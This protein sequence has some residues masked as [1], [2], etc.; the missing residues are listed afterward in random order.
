MTT[1]TTEEQICNIALSWIG[2]DTVTD[3]DT[4]GTERADLCVLHYPVCRDNV[5]TE[6][7]WTF[8]V[9][10]N[11]LD[12]PDGTAP[13]NPEWGQRFPI[14]ST[15]LRVLTVH[16]PT[17]VFTD[18]L[19]DSEPSAEQIPWVREGDWIL[20]NYDE[21]S[22]RTIERITTVADFPDVFVQALAARLAMD[23][24]IPLTQSLNLHQQMAAMYQDKMRNAAAMDGMQGRSRRIRHRGL[25]ARR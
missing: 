21:I 22:V 14:A 15:T 23:L 18:F 9:E 6:R 17:D 2:A 11:I 19:T 24:A 4:D 12:T 8:A 10:H 25:L 3:I 7:E 13:T 1:L 5:L 16:P 20:C